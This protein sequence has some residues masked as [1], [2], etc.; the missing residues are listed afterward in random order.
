MDQKG[1]DP[2]DMGRDENMDNKDA[3]RRIREEFTE[4]IWQGTI[5]EIRVKAKFGNKTQENKG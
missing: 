3:R 5:E 2:R 4:K 1:G